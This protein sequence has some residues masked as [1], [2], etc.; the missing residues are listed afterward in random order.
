MLKYSLARLGLFA[1]CF[2]ASYAVFGTGLIAVADPIL[3]S[4]L[5]GAIVS[6]ALS[7]WLLAGLREAV[8]DRINQRVADAGAERAANRRS[9]D[10]LAEDEEDEARY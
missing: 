4:V 9:A 10:E 5:V 7:F 1:V 6:M 3:W 2:A 8:S